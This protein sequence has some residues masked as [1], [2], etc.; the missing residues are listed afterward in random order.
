MRALLRKAGQALSEFDTRYA[1]RVRKDSAK[2]PLTQML[3]GIP[4]GPVSASPAKELAMEMAKE[5]KGPA[6]KGMIQRHQAAEYAL[7]AG[8]VATNAAYR[9]GLPA[10]GAT[11]ALKG[12]IDMANVIGQQTP[13]TLEPN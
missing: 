7:G 2:L 10:A 6:S 13:T 12:A 8:V 5:G 9:Y 1:E 3:G 4:I 11:L